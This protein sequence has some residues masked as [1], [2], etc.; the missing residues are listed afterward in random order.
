[1][2]RQRKVR[3]L[4]LQKKI[5]LTALI[6]I[7]LPFSLAVLLEPATALVFLFFG[8]SKV[9]FFFRRCR[10][11]RWLRLGASMADRVV[12]VVRLGGLV[13][14]GIVGDFKVMIT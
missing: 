13:W 6:P 9:T 1:M 4:F 5:R 7:F 8:G 12:R 3:D 14:L 11:R 10:V 2:D